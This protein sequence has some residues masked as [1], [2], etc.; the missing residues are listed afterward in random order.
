[1]V[2]A[3]SQSKMEVEFGISLIIPA[4]TCVAYF[5]RSNKGELRNL[6]IIAQKIPFDEQMTYKAIIDIDG[7][8]WSSR[9]AG[10]LCTSSSSLRCAIFC[11][12]A[13]FHIIWYFGNFSWP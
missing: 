13:L 1:M 10:L 5:G 12:G 7:K 11:L 4:I 3:V 9:F 6:T 2:L 8:N